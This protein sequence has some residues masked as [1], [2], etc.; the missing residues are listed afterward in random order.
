MANVVS[1][2]TVIVTKC[3]R[4]AFIAHPT[5]ARKRLAIEDTSP[6]TVTYRDRRHLLSEAHKLQGVLG[7]NPGAQAEILK[8]GEA[9]GAGLKLPLG[10]WIKQAAGTT[11][12][13]ETPKATA[14]VKPLPPPGELDDVEFPS[15]LAAP[16]TPGK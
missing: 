8:T 9:P 16:A 3:R 12:P 6:M 14:E 13:A 1:S 15:V 5:K 7:G 11:L 4:T 10:D 2:P